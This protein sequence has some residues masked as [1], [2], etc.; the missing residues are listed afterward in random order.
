MGDVDSLVPQVVSNSSTSGVRPTRHSPAAGGS[1]DPIDVDDDPDDD[2]YDSAAD[3]NP[4]DAQEA[5]F[6]HVTTYLKK[7]MKK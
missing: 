5:W 6:P 3:V 2:G 4:T 7:M 1:D